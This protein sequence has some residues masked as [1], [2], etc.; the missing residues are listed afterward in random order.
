M[1]Y[2]VASLDSAEYELLMIWFLHF[3]KSFDEFWL[4][5]KTSFVAFGIC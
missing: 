4:L 3:P 1:T 2:F 5:N